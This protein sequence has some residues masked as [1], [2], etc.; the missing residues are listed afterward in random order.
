M[1]KVHYDVGLKMTK[2]Q[3]VLGWLYLPFFALLTALGIQLLA[4]A[5]KLPLD[6]YTLNIAYMCVNLVFVLLVYHRF[7]LKSFRGFT[8]DFWLFVQT[9]IL[10]FALNYILSLVL[11]AP[12]IL[13]EDTTA[14]NKVVENLL[15][16]NTAVMMIL[17]IV[18]A[19]IVEET[20]VRGVIFG[21]LHRKNRILAYAASILFFTA[22]HVWQYAG[23][24]NIGMLLANC[25]AYIAP[26]VA[27][28]W[29]YEKSGTILCPI[30][31]HA[32]INA[33]ACGVSLAL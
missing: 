16:Q 31:L 11:S 24:M 1:A 17:T 2:T 30:L 29:T 32:V 20:L 3:M 15:G 25:A 12:L 19:P 4:S 14:N 13:L 23:T 9:L 26:S 33:L 6:E 18:A 8:E 10:G 21:S 7:L 27:L 28:G 5:L 22:I